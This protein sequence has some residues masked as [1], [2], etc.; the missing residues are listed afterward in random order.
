VEQ[1]FR[2]YLEDNALAGFGDRIL[3]AVSGG[4]DSVVMAHLFAESDHTC[5]IAHC[6]FQLRGLDSDEDEE[7]VR[8]L[9]ARLEM[10]LYVERFDVEREMQDRGISLQMAARD[11]RYAWF[12]DLLDAH[13]YSSLA[14][15]HN[16]N[17]SVES[18]F[19][20]LS[21]GTGIRGLTGI[22]VRNR[23]VIRPLRFAGR[24]EIEA[25]ALAKGIQFREDASNRETKYQ[26]N[27]IRHDVIPHM[28][29]LQPDFVQIMA[30]NMKRLEETLSLAEGAVEA[31]KAKLFRKDGEVIRISVEALSALS[32]QATW[33]YEL[34]SPYGFSRQQCEGILGIMDARPGKR[35][36]SSSHQLYKDREELI[37]VRNNPGGFARYYLDS[38][39]KFSS[40]PF[41]MDVEVLDREQL[42]EIPREASMA[43][44]DYHEIEFPLTIRHW[45][46][47]DYFYPLGMNQM[48]KLS[49]FFVDEKVPVP[50]KESTWILA[51]GRKIVWIMGRRIDHRFRITEATRRVLLL[52]LQSNVGSQGS[53]EGL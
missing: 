50:E 33:I 8:R 14:T 24:K 52:R 39:E 27:K 2:T 51:S 43:C 5:A 1:A 30:G 16:L 22:P 35:S 23:R 10:P 21:R 53:E 6:N 25:Y 41:A 31:T 7:F 40:L 46:P 26:R 13:G 12:G 20:N 42:G 37:L 36:L 32:P 9:A 4:V 44:L 19:L 28:E 38:P 18:F 48:K 17:D 15:A 29:T 34:F 47:G 45:H 11:L 49:D 3:L